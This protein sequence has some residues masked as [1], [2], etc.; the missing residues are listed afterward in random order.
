MILSDSSIHCGKSFVKAF[1]VKI[2][3]K[4][5]NSKHKTRN[6]KHETRNTSMKRLILI[7]LLISIQLLNA[8]TI[9]GLIPYPNSLIKENGTFLFDKNT[10]WTVQNQEQQ[11]VLEQV[12]EKFKIAANFDYKVKI[13]T[14]SKT[15][16][17]VS[18]LADKSIPEEGYKLTVNNKSIVIQASTNKGFYYGI[19]TL[20]QLLPSSIHSGRF[21]S[22][23]DWSVAGVS[24]TDAPR[25]GY[26]GFMLDVSRYFIPK[27]DVLR[28]ID[29]LAY[30]KINYFHW[31]LTDDNGWRIEIKK[32]PRL[33]D[34]GAWRVERTE[35]FSMRRN[36]EFG[37]AATQGGY[38][39]QDDIREVVKYAQERFVEIIP[40]IEMPAHSNAALAAYPNLT[41][42]VVDHFISVLPGMGG[43]NAATTFCAGNDSVFTFFEDVLSEVMQLFPSKYIHIGGDEANKENWEKCP[44]CQARM[45]ANNI[46]NEE[47]LQSY[48]I[49]RINKFLISHNKHLMG[50]DELVDSEIPAG[51]TIFGWRGM[52]TAAEVA[53][54]KGFKYI[55]SSAIKYY[56][57]RYQGPQWFEPFTYFG[58]TTL[59]DV[60]DYE[61]LEKTVP[62]SVSNNMLGIEACLW[63]EFVNSTQDA[64]YLIFPRL[65]AFAES[66]WTQPEN[67]NWSSFATRIDKVLAVYDFAGINYAK[68][69]Y[70][71]DHNVRPANGNV[72]VEL[73]SI[74]PDLE[75]RYTTDESEPNSQSALYNKTLIVDAGTSIRA[76]T[77][78]NG[79]AIGKILPLNFMK[80]KAI[81][82]KVYSKNTNAYI[83]T[84]GIRGSEKMTDG[85]WIDLYDTDFECVIELPNVVTCSQIGLGMLNNVGMGVH[86]PSEVTFS[87]SN[88]NLNYKPVLTKIYT[89]NERFKNGMFRFT[90]QFDIG[91]QTFKYLKMNAKKP[92]NTPESMQREGQKNRMAFDEVL[93]N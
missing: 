33:T 93:L 7:S 48:F 56:F 42:P 85:E 3:S 9:Q 4:T 63:A 79:V 52:G 92:G 37:E 10:S 40:E 5:R 62:D 68:S 55:K 18:L 13:S 86:L 17:G 23:K 39:T 51:A 77:F 59:K 29:L 50:W 87:I 44:K 90:E 69:M 46:P 38:Y 89:E 11:K 19:Q 8:N 47:E 32:H 16:K 25:F 41:C 24:I 36:A 27:K 66:A 75:I 22:Q 84:N 88:D 78:L 12:L 6:T 53:G 57:I 82:A 61:P 81:G 83:L 30:H 26:R 31:H 71:I 43:K 1:K 76:R 21:V 65:A 73:S 58:N 54:A 49:K 74:R 35:N 20:S 45:K 14:K 15:S 70:N 60:Y 67:K 80:H 91:N 28:L 34:I 64:E 2:E 72:S